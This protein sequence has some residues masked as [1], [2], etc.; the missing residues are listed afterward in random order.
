[1]GHHGLNQCLDVHTVANNGQRAGGA[2]ALGPVIELVSTTP[3]V[4]AQLV[5]APRDNALRTDRAIDG[6]SMSY[7]IDYC[8][9]I[10]DEVR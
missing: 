5:V 9:V 2:H 10:G 6:V 4:Y 8:E 7:L 3:L 1:M